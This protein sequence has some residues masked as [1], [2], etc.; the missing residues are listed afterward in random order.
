MADEAVA[1]ETPDDAPLSE[2]E[3]P[4]AADPRS[5]RK[6]RDRQSRN[7]HEASEFWKSVFADP[8][9]RREMWAMLRSCHAHEHRFACSPNGSP[10][11]EAAWF[12]RGEEATGERLFKSWLVA[13][14]EGVMLMLREHDPDFAKPARTPKPKDD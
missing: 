12:Q 5:I 13:D 11:P 14:P 6:K 3:V 9:G 8:V 1:G 7:K 10:Y 2:A 4:N